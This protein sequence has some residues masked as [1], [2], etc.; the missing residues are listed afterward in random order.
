MKPVWS[1]GARVGSGPDHQ[2]AQT[3]AGPPQKS[4][5]GPGASPDGQ[6]DSESSS[7]NPPDLL[8]LASLAQTGLLCGPRATLR[9]P[10]HVWYWT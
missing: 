10:R 7:E 9:L 1:S 2:A 5:R 3:A 6:T 8:D 4:P